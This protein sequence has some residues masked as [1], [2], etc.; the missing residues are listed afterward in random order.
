MTRERSVLVWFVLW[1]LLVAAVA[2]RKDREGAD[3]ATATQIA[4]SQEAATLTVALAQTGTTA[5]QT[6]TT[7]LTPTMTPT[8]TP[9]TP[10]TP[11]ET[12]CVPA[13]GWVV[14]NVLP[15]ETL[16]SIAARYGMTPEELQEANCLPSAGEI[17][18]GQSLYVPWHVTPTP[19]PCL[20]PAGWVA[21][22]V[23]PDETLWAIAVRYD[24]TAEELQRAN[25]LDSSVLIRAGQSIRVPYTIVPTPR[26]TPTPIPRPTNTPIP[27]D[28]PM[29]TATPTPTVDPANGAIEGE[30]FMSPGSA[31]TDPVCA[32][33]DEDGPQIVLSPRERDR[34]QLCVYG[35]E[36]GDDITVSLHAPNI[37][38][39][40]SRS[41][42]VGPRR[43]DGRT[44]VGVYLWM[45][46]GLPTTG[47]YASASS[48]SKDTG[49]TPLH[50]QPYE[51]PAINTMPDKT[52][53]PFEDHRCGSYEPDDWV[54]VHGTQFPKDERLPLALYWWTKKVDPSSQGRYVLEL[55]RGQ[56]THTD[57]EGD[58]RAAIRVEKDDPAGITWVVP[59][60]DTT[61]AEFDRPD[62]HI[63]CYFV[64][65]Q[66]P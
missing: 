3:Q 36:P 46:V 1:L 31:G 7:Q 23:L 40:D 65:E 28:T 26:P 45:P 16:Y 20:P 52:I 2:C 50:L 12:P 43:E 10:L 54:I 17:R 42:T 8:M 35:F 38:F 25:C 34:Y 30:A 15:G 39:F 53:S 37:D 48:P 66:N 60:T 58:F 19:T 33:P 59:V 18:A 13:E 14:Y 21:Y 56:W 44:V 55:A 9:T 32:D 62:Q 6:P 22:S 61:V 11:T 57:G 41:F 27:T 29:P 64:E 47:W 24:M 63:Q 5:P 49:N 4:R 51:V